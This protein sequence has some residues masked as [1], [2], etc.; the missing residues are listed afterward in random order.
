[1]RVHKNDLDDKGWPKPGA[2]RNRAPEGSP[3]TDADGMST[4]WEKYST[5]QT[6]LERA[7]TPADNIVICLQVGEVRSI[8]EQKVE[9]TPL[10]TAPD[11]AIGNRSHTDVRGNKKR[12]PEVRVKFRR[13]CLIA[14]TLGSFN[15][16][17]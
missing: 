16:E 13:A 6:T 8:P 5:A 7:R 4:D 1:M 9:H 10:Q 17:A 14:E 15:V 12:N 3:L 2:F 11:D